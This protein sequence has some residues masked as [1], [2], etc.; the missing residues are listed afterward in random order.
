MKLAYCISIHL[1]C[2]LTS[3]L[4][5]FDCGSHKFSHIEPKE[6]E[7]ESKDRFLQSTTY[8]K[9][10][11][12]FDYTGLEEA[13]DELE[14]SFINKVKEIMNS[15]S[16]SFST[17]VS[18]KPYSSKL[19]INECQGITFKIPDSISVD[20]VEADL[21]LFVTIANSDATS[22]QTEAY[23][24]SCVVDSSTGRPIAGVV[25]LNVNRVTFSKVNSF[26][27]N[28]LLIMHE[29]THVLAFNRSLFK[30]FINPDTGSKKNLDETLR[31]KVMIN[32]VEK[33]LIVS[34]NVRKKAAEYFDCPSIVG[35]E[36]ESQGGTGSAGS[37]WEARTMLG[38]YMIA[39]S[40]SEVYI[41]EITLALFEDSGWYKV[42]YY[43]GGLQKFGNFAG[44]DF[45]DKKCVEEGETLD[46][47]NYCKK[48]S[49]VQ[50]L[51]GKAYRGVC[52]LSQY[53]SS[54]PTE[55]QYYDD[56]TVGSP[57][58]FADYCP[59]VQG[60]DFDP[61]YFYSGSCI[62]G[63]NEL[64]KKYNQYVGPGSACFTSSLFETQ[65][66]VITTISETIFCYKYKCDAETTSII[67]TFGE[68]S[69]NCPG[70]GG[71]L[72]LEGFT[73]Y[74]ICPKYNNVCTSEIE[75]D[76]TLDCI[77]K[78]SKRR[79]AVN[80]YFPAEN[81]NIIGTAQKAKPM[82]S[83][84]GET[85]TENTDN[86]NTNI[87]PGSDTS[88]NE[89]VNETTVTSISIEVTTT[90]SNTEIKVEANNSQEPIDI[91]SNALTK[92]IS[93][94]TIINIFTFTVMIL[95]VD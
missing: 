53:N 5:A 32:G 59:I 67:V 25:A 9:I 14:Y 11:I 15:V 26:Q 1:L 74:I 39:Q 3:Y 78:M 51:P 46:E 29:I 83:S 44:C 10:R 6:V 77:I 45:L 49:S 60:Y 73:G 50:C 84:S 62:F 40:Y 80:S 31:E 95:I 82:G 64:D 17:L 42:N 91:N 33:D 70:G 23:A 58:L 68:K 19:I 85:T 63:V 75:C 2:I 89:S 37:H 76:D 57:F 65:S 79:P 8:E 72:Y 38:D 81:Y 94:S 7:V 27:Y 86:T 18:L 13:S 48:D 43:T 61:S 66:S 34:Y 21:V 20:G 16:F 35:V 87:D 93:L 90:N 88:I 4:I 12:H 56:S 22:S 92:V 30:F 24:Y 47:L 71:M 36:L 55:Y 41:S 54:L 69:F 52:A 28:Y